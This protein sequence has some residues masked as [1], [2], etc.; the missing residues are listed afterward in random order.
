MTDD[1]YSTDDFESESYGPVTY[2]EFLSTSTPTLAT[3]IS[4]LPNT[5]NE[6]AQVYTLTKTVACLNHNE[7]L[8]YKGKSEHNTTLV[9]STQAEILKLPTPE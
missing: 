5:D 4:T 1:F 9:L 7:K 2:E 8:F 3:T 6:V